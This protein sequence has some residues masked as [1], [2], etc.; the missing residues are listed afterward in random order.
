[1]NTPQETPRSQPHQVSPG[2]VNRLPS[3]LS[4]PRLCRP[5]T[6]HSSPASSHLSQGR[7]PCSRPDTSYVK[8]HPY[9]HS[10]EIHPSSE[11]LSHMTGTDMLGRTEL[12]TYTGKPS[13]SPVPPHSYSHPSPPLTMQLQVSVS[14][15][16]T[17]DERKSMDPPDVTCNMYP[18]HQNRICPSHGGVSPFSANHFR[19]SLDTIHNPSLASPTLQPETRINGE[20]KSKISPANHSRFITNGS[21]LPR[22]NFGP[23]LRD[24]HNGLSTEFDTAYPASDVQVMD[25][26]C[27]I[28]LE[29]YA[30]AR[31]QEEPE[32]LSMKPKQAQGVS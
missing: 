5:E 7:S 32:D 28:K 31:E 9:H 6:S 15:Y 29:S 20:V 10:D 30:S 27:P 25:L 1:E 17:F 2:S 13:L 24:H 12:L 22:I 14:Q 4:V 26:S 23:N 3:C 19:R 8:P 16:P 21:Y 11:L 18:A